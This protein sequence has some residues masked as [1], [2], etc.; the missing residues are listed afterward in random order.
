[1]DKRKEQYEKLRAAVY[2]VIYPDGIPVEKGVEFEHKSRTWSFIRM[3]LGKFVLMDLLQ[4]RPIVLRDEVFEVFDDISELEVLGKPLSLR[5][6]LRAIGDD[7]QPTQLNTNGVMTVFKADKDGKTPIC[8]YQITID[9]YKSI[10]EQDPETLD[11][12]Y[13]LIKS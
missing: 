5:S 12:L 2:S 6:L 13:K 9:F 7:N 8:D 11:K 3:H 4:W 10:K 1:M